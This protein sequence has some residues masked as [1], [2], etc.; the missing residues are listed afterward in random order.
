MKDSISNEDFEFISR[1][2]LDSAA[3]NIEKGKEQFV[4]AR[5]LPVAQKFGYEN[6]AALVSELKKS[7][8]ENIGR[9]IIESL[10]THETSFFRDSIP[11]EYLKNHIIPEILSNKQQ[12]LTIWCGASSSG[13]EPCSIAM[14]LKEYFP[15]AFKKINIIASDLSEA[16]LTQAKSGKYSQF[17]VN[18]GLSQNFLDKYFT[19]NENEYYTIKAEILDMISYQ[20]QNLLHPFSVANN[21]D[22]VFLRN[23][24]IYFN[25]DTRKEILFKIKEILKPG[26]FL[27]LGATETTINIDNSFERIQ[28]SNTSCYKNSTMK[29]R[30]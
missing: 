5:I 10:T 23:V 16:I 1:F 18:R 11:F 22:I 13:Q 26:G 15:N 19:K 6:I 8:S 29:G 14:L 28:T 4:E 2:A 3:I 21:V 7:K 17:Q 25:I 12:E 24:L 30:V 27:F 20:Q 9:Q